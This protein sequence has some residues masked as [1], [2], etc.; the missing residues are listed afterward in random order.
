[1]KENSV[2]NES[3][4]SEVLSRTEVF[5]EKNKKTI[6]YAVSAVAIVIIAF[7][8]LRHFYFQPREV[9]AAEDMFV[10]EN[11]FDNGNY[12]LALKGDDNALGFLDII[13]DYSCTKSGNLARYYAGICE[14]QMGQ[15][16][17]A[18]KHLKKYKA[19]DTFTKA[20]RL[21]LMGDAEAEMENYDD[22][23]DYYEKAAEV[24]KNFVTSPAAIF[25]AAL[26]YMNKGDNKKAVE[27]FE[28]IKRNY[29][30]ST[31]SSVVDSY[32]GHAEVSVAE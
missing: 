28:S 27:M 23:I 7:F 29:P 12:E 26:L 15:Y 3:S 31:E 1:M 22:A 4:I 14:L 9:R 20:E 13:D 5:L 25:K 32:I 19:R 21:M 30:E 2:N 6:I 8:G 11:L 17:D 16:E 24:E 18:L 10:A